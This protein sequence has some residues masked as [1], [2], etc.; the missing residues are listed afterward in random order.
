MLLHAFS[1]AALAMPAVASAQR[2]SGLPAWLHLSG[3]QRTRYEHLANRFQTA[4]PGNDVALAL[5]TTLLAELRFN[6]VAMGFELAD[7]RVYM[8]GDDTPLNTTHVNPLD[9]LQ[10]YLAA[11]LP[12]FVARGAHLRM[13][14]GRQT[15]EIGSRRLVARNRFRNTI[16]ALTGLSLE[17][18][19]PAAETVRAFVT[20]PVERR[21]SSLTDNGLRLDIERT[22][23]VFW[24]TVV[25]VRPW[26]RS[27]QVEL[28]LFGLHERDSDEYQTGNRNFVT[29]A[30]RL[31][32]A[33]RPGRFDFE[34]E[35]AVQAGTS[36]ST[37]LPDDTT[38]LRHFAYFA[39]GSIG[40][41]IAGGWQPRL[42]LQY[43]YASGDKDP[44]DDANGRF[45]TLFG[46]RRF[47]F[48]PTGFYGAFARSNI[49]SPGS[50]VEFRP[51]TRVD[52]FLAY[53]PVWLAQAR[54]GWTTTQLRD[55]NGISGTF[56]GHQL[57]GEGRWQLVN[58]RV[59]VETG[60]ALLRLGGFPRNA[61]GGSPDRNDPAYVYTQM[62]LRF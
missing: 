9:L 53:R 36:R 43:D 10:A 32:R 21:V 51:H 15:M 42:V 62:I 31:V 35:T 19:G 12:D 14:L 11:E 1:V 4:T 55:R 25:S 38:R 59:T 39:H 27:V 23:S 48:G 17:W 5:R 28:Q 49:N 57:E 41:S 29:P 34:I 22:E 13:Q 47:E 50:R 58:R 46:A 8:T 33:R 18:T 54:D 7:S 26:W 24:G 16:N 52:G 3:T 6:P 20:V 40:V 30:L 2:Q 61:P 44:S 60:F 37:A 45:D 56:L